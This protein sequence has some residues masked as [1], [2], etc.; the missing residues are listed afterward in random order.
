[1][2]S[3]TIQISNRDQIPGRI[4]KLINYFRTFR[5]Y[6]FLNSVRDYIGN[7]KRNHTNK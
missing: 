6:I 4:R 1:M 2:L 5:N 3:E 7:V